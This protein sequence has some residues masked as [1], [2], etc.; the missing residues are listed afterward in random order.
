MTYSNGEEYYGD[1]YK[2]K[3]WGHG[4]ITWECGINCDGFWC[5]DLMHGLQDCYD[6]NGKS[7]IYGY[8]EDH[9]Y[10]VGSKEP[11]W[12]SSFSK[13]LIYFININFSLLS[14]MFYI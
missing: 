8:F 7:V 9:K 5:D 3:R 12:F 10:N 11:D 14:M 2:G 4:K 13:F 6:K 1:F